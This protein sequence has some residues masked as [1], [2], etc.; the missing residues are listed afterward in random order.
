MLNTQ[1]ISQRG[2]KQGSVTYSK[3]REN[4]VSKT[5]NLLYISEVNHVS[6]KGKETS[7]AGHTVEYSPQN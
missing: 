4:E 2:K 1:A 3:G 7:M 6:R 5:F